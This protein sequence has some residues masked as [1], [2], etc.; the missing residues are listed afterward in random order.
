M[1]IWLTIRIRWVT[2]TFVQIVMQNA[3]SDA[4]PENGIAPHVKK[5]FSHE[6]MT[7]SEYFE[8]DMDDLSVLAAADPYWER[9]YAFCLQIAK[10]NI[11]HL[12]EGEFEWLEKISSQLNGH[13]IPIR[14]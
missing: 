8:I 10:K 3:G 7:A 1:G 13:D 12:T 2:H 11:G 5:L 9:A 14:H 4:K 6:S